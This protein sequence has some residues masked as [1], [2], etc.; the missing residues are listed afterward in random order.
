MSPTILVIDDNPKVRESLEIA[1]PEYQ[2]TGA[3]NGEDGLKHLRRSHEVDL[4]ML[5]YKMD[6]LDGLDVLKE[7]RR[8]DPKMGVIFLT[9]F[10][11]REVLLEALRGRADDFIDK[12]YSIEETRK[13]IRNFFKGR[14]E[15]ERNSDS[16]GGPIRRIQAFVERNSSKNPTLK[17]AAEKTLL[18][19]KYVSR[20]FKQETCQTFSSYKIK[21]KMNLAKKLLYDTSLSVVQIAYKVGYGNAESFMKMFKKSSGCTPTEYRQKEHAG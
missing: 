15:E 2:F 9:S 14:N 10:G 17:E 1:F 3:L 4:V 21:L 5:D 19:P 8:M 11:T 7:I 13:K 20:K 6:G 12:P 18:S 16:G